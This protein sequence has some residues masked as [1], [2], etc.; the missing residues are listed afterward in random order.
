MHDV[1]V[2]H[3]D[4]PIEKHATNSYASPTPILEGDR[5]WVHFGTM[6]TAC[7]D[8]RP[9]RSFGSRRNCNS[10]TKSGPAASPALFEDL[11]LFNCDG[12]DVQYG[13]ALDKNTGALVW[14]TNR[15]G[16]ITKPND[17][18]KAFVTPLVIQVDGARW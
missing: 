4:K 5:V 10:T 6:G 9:P 1:E 18:K 2:F 15:S 3:R 14:K 7:L 8:T 11:L 16:V 12:T 17:R 13:A